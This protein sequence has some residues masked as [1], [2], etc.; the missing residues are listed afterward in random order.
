MDIVFFGTTQLAATI[1]A[2]QI[3]AKEAL[4]GLLAQINK[5]NPVLDL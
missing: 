3:S 1:R 5:H 2:G 4:E